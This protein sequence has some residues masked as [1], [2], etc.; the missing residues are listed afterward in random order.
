[1]SPPEDERPSRQEVRL[2]AY[3]EELRE[4]PP[5]P[6]TSLVLR[7]TKHLRW[8]RA[9]RSPLRAVGLFAAA[10]LDGLSALIGA[11]TGPRS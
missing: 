10:V 2:G 6:G 9:F 1:M 7:V 8:Q 3:L 11:G 4:D 5:R